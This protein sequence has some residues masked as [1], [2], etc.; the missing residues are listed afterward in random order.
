M[1]PSTIKKLLK[2]KVGSYGHEAIDFYDTEVPKKDSN[3]TCLS[4]ILIDFVF[5]NDDSY[6]PQ[7][8]LK[9][10]K[11]TKK[12]KKRLGIWWLKKFFWWLRWAWR[13]VN[14][15]MLSFFYNERYNPLSLK[16]EKRH[17]VLF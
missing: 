7:V 1:N 16:R 8:F 17:E 5:K 15:I 4:I 9:G 10:C 6:Y 3:Y 2:N 12:K 14:W 11:Y 13:K